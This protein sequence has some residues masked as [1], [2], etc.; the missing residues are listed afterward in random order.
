LPTIVREDGFRFYF[1]SNEGNEPPHVHVSKGSGAAKIW[2]DP[3]RIA[4]TEGFNPSEMR[5][6]REIVFANRAMFLRRWYEHF[7]R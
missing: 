1:F 5:R 6:L 3:L 4:Y 2:L 7:A